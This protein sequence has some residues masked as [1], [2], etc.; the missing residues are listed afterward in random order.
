[1]VFLR[2]VGEV[3]LAHEAASDHGRVRARH[4]HNTG[5]EQGQG[6]DSTG[7]GGG[8]GVYNKMNRGGSSPRCGQRKGQDRERG[9]YRLVKGAENRREVSRPSFNHNDHTK[10]GQLVSW[11]WSI[12]SSVCKSNY[13][14]ISCMHACGNR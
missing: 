3:Q 12:T 2:V 11:S 1:M 5:L 6:Q 4:R 13:V 14:C 7:Q 10:T 8:G 9:V